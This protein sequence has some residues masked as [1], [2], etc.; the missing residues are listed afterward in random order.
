VVEVWKSIKG[1][2]GIYE[3]SN[4]GR[5]KTLSRIIRGRKMPEKIKKLDKTKQGYLRVELSKN[6][7]KKKY[8][9]HRLVAQTFIENCNKYPCVNHKDENPSNNS[10][11][12]LEWCTHLYNNLYNNKHKRNCK[13]IKQLDKNY[14]V[15]NI[16]ESVNEASEKNKIIRNEISNCLNK[17]QKTAGGYHWQYYDL[18][19]IESEGE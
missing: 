17:R 12:N 3:I 9:V 10:V 6:K 13:K 16:F 2:E 14:N 8:S 5:I 4:L 7:S 1:Y 19:K 15:I 11:D 18:D